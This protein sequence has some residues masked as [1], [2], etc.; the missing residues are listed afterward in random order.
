MLHIYVKYITED[1]GNEDVELKCPQ[2]SYW[3]HTQ[4]WEQA[5]PI[6]TPSIQ[7]VSDCAMCREA[8]LVCASS[9]RHS[10]TLLYPPPP[11]VARWGTASTA[12]PASPDCTSLSVSSLL[13]NYYERNNSLFLSKVRCCHRCQ[14]SNPLK[15]EAPALHPIKV[16]TANLL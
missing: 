15:T 5:C 2:P 10:C 9:S 1:N 8:L 7:F 12:S 14:L 4:K 6:C 3:K 11:L 13:D 16:V